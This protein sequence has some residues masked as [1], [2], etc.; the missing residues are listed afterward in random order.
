MSLRTIVKVSNVT[1]LSDARY[2]AGMGVEFIGFSIDETDPQHLDL[3]KSQEIRSWL[4]GVQIVAETRADTLGNVLEKLRDYAPDLVQTNQADWLPWLKMELGKPLI[5]SI[6]A[7]QDA[8]NIVELMHKNADYVQYFLLQSESNL[9][10]DGDWPDF[11]QQLAAQ[12]P[13]LLGFGIN[14]DTISDLLAST[15]LSGIALSGNTE[16]RPGYSEFGNLMDVLEALE[17]MG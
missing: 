7:N 14:A 6:E 5:L 4:A 3:K 2:C 1:N 16:I 13:I 9:T 12:F 10:L 15:S 11:L 17:E 8:D